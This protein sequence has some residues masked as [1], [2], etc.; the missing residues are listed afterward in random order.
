MSVIFQGEPFWLPGPGPLLSVPAN[1]ALVEHLPS[2]WAEHPVGKWLLPFGPSAESPAAQALP[3]W[4]KN[5]NTAIRADMDE[6]RFAQTYAQLLAEE[7]QAQSTGEAPQRSRSETMKLVGNR[8][9]NFYIMKAFGSQAPF[10]TSPQGRLEWYR[11]EWNRY[12]EE[13]G[14]D[15][16]DKF[17]EDYP[18]YFDMTISLSLNET[19]VRA[20]DAAMGEV[21]KYRDLVAQTPE[22][23]WAFAGAANLGGEFSQGAYQQQKRQKIGAGTAKTWRTIKDPGEAYNEVQVSK[24]WAEWN[25]FSTEL[26][27][28]L[29][30]AGMTIRSKGAES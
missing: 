17:R 23:G 26:N 25:K 5:V 16:E 27:L 4:V 3:Q 1:E 2:S 7:M 15:A 18:D 19:G 20:S 9:R 11:Q 12:I 21:K 6:D 22:Y 28:Q 29:E 14:K 10:S 8:A 30:A 24:G 13:Y